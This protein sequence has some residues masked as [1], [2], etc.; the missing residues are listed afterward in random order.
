MSEQLRRLQEL[1][2]REEMLLSGMQD[3]RAMM[4]TEEELRRGARSLET[5]SSTAAFE[6]VSSNEYE[7]KDPDAPGA[8]PG[9]QEGP[10]AH[11]LRPLGVTSFGEDGLERVDTGRLALKN[12]SATGELAREKADRADL[13]ELR[14]RLDALSI[15]TGGDDPDE[16]LREARSGRF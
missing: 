13:D 14:D 4:P 6:D 2:D 10:M 12:A 1:Q 5:P 8:A 7:Y 9:R 16:T 11:E 3:E 15:A